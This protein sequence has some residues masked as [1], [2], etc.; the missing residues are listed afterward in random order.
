[1][2]FL[3][4]FGIPGLVVLLAGGIYLWK[5]KPKVRGVLV[6]LILTYVILDGLNWARKSDRFIINVFLPLL[7]VGLLGLS[8]MLAKW[9]RERLLWL[10][11]LLL[12]AA[13][14]REMV[15]I[16]QCFNGHDTRDI[17]R[18]WILQ[19]IPERSKIAREV[20]Y[21]PYLDRKKFD[22][23][24]ETWRV[25]SY[26]LDSLRSLGIEYVIFADTF[27]GKWGSNEQI[28]KNYREFAALSKKEFRMKRPPKLND[29][30]GP[31]IRISKIQ[32]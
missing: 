23:V 26:T 30:H 32:K 4:E 15:S 19:N 25:G 12:L 18:P 16:F 11:P 6:C 3:H 2:A 17:A 31:T 22:V 1:L 8:E 20:I 9:R 29:F 10:F 21:T 7:V 14:G 27:R 24:M 13:N 28:Q 5:Q